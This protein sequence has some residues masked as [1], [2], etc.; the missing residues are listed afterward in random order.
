M[1]LVLFYSPLPSSFP[2]RA[3]FPQPTHKTTTH[4]QNPHQDPVAAT[5]PLA[6]Q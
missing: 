5:S 1:T 2:Q 4:H 6:N 3:H